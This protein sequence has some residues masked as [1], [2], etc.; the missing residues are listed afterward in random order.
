MYQE[1]LRRIGILKIEGENKMFWTSEKN[2]QQYLA[3]T[4]QQM[5]RK[6]QIEKNNYHATGNLKKAKIFVSL[7]SHFAFPSTENH[8]SEQVIFS[9]QSIPLPGHQAYSYST[10]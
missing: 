6:R 4:W 3:K 7:V 2:N 10:N 8:E 9:N 5:L 1:R